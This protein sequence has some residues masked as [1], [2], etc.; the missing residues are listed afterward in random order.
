MVGADCGRAYEFDFRSGQKIGVAA[1]AGAHD[2]CV[3]I[4]HRIAVDKA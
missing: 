3:G 4:G 1:G 2:Q